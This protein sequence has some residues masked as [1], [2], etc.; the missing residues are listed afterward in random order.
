MISEN[1]AKDTRNL[2][3]NSWEIIDKPPGNLQ[4]FS[5]NLNTYFE[6]ILERYEILII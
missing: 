1:F 3:S 2:P 4:K 6:G 5:H